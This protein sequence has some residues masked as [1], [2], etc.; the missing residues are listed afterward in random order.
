MMWGQWFFFC[1]GACY[2]IACMNDKYKGFSTQFVAIILSAG[3]A[4]LV[5]FFQVLATS[6]GLCPAVQSTTAEAGVLGATF[7]AAHTGYLALAHK[8][9]L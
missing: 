8:S 4:A 2:H 9:F 5:T 3:A 7:K 1:S 6:G